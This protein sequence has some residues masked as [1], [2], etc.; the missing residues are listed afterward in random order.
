M[1]LVKAAASDTVQDAKSAGEKSETALVTGIR[2]STKESLDVK[3]DS[4]AVVDVIPSEDVGKF[5]DKNIAEAL[6]CVSGV[7]ISRE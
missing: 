4:Q 1:A 3:R 6:Q 5:P 7:S 2:A